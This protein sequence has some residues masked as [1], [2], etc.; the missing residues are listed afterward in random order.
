LQ[1]GEVKI[2][3]AAS[4]TDL[5]KD[6]TAAFIADHPDVK[7]KTNFGPSGG[8]AKQIDQGAPADFYV[9]ANPKWMDFLVDKNRIDASTKKI[10]AHNTLVFVGM[11]DSGV[12]EL[13]DLPKLE[14]IALGSPKSV[15]AGQYA[16]EAL[17]KTSLWNR[18]L[19]NGKLVMAKD[20]RQALIYADR[21]E[22]DGSFVYRTDALL[23]KKAKVLFEVPQKLYNKVT[24]PA[25]LTLTGAANPDAAAF[26]D[27][28]TS[29]VVHEKLIRYGFALPE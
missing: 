14:R 25:A 19:D 21:G 24:Y 22:T 5:F 29:H 6:L 1:A 12:S 11:E 18:L 9:S 20:V 4:M 15:P 7:I 28:V 2:S 8:L 3:V 23:A 10:F 16:R 27:Y 13:A 17:E 26:Y